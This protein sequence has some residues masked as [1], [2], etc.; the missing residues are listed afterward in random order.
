MEAIVRQRG[1]KNPPFNPPFKKGGKLLQS[2]G[3]LQHRIEQTVFSRSHAPAWECINMVF[4]VA[5]I[6]ACAGMTAF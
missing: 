6:P 1:L 4:Q 5:W 2:A 3:T